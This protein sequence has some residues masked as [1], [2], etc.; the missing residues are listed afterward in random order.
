MGMCGYMTSFS[1]SKT[2]R[3]DI[4]K[5]FIMGVDLTQLWELVQQFSK[6]VASASG[7]G[8]KS[9]GQAVRKKSMHRETRTKVKLSRL[10]TWMV[11]VSCRRN[12]YSSSQSSACT[13]LGSQSRWRSGR[14]WEAAAPAQ[15]SP[16]R[17]AGT[18]LT[19][20][21]SCPQSVVPW[22]NL[23]SLKEHAFCFTSTYQ[24]SHTM[25]LASHIN[26]EGGK[27]GSLENLFLA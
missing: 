13:W 25:S 22:T 9:A 20:S 14:S 17:W 24:I 18:W 26:V 23:L 6:T 12:S 2:I 19:T 1:K 27:R 4:E 8:L 7:A 11:W 5:E 15:P 16:T 10:P 3:N 21:E